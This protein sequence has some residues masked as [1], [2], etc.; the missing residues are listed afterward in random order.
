MLLNCFQQREF[1]WGILLSVYKLA[2]ANLPGK[3]NGVQI[4][5]VQS[6]ENLIATGGLFPK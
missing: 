5:E 3:N 6:G 2:V 4:I 1:L